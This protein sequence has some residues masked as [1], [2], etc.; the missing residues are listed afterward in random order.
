MTVKSRKR[1]K[2]FPLKVIFIESY[3]YVK[4][5]ARRICT[6]SN[7]QQIHVTHKKVLS[8]KKN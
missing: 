8:V 5:G 7:G 1:Q 4:E 3:F 6:G 2:D